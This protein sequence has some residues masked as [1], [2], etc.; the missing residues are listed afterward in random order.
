MRA[1]YARS[2]LECRSDIG[3][4]FGIQLCFPRIV[5]IVSSYDER[6]RSELQCYTRLAD[7]QGIY[8]TT[9]VLG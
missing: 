1:Y 5:S 3:V 4:F 8:S 6:G 7:A 2:G 9:G